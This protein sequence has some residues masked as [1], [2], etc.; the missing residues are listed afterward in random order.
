MKLIYNLL[1]AGLI[2][3][4]AGC[5]DNLDVSPIDNIDAE[6]ALETSAD[7]E[8]LV[9]GAYDAMGDGDL[10]GG[11]MQRDAELLADDGD[12]FWDGTFVAPGEIWTK[13][14]QITND[15]A[16]TTWLDAYRAINI[17]NL[18]LDNLDLVVEAKR[19]TV[20]GDAKFVRGLM[21]FEL[22]RLY[23]KTYTD[24]NPSTNPGVP[25]ILTPAS[26]DN[27]DENKKVTRASVDAIYQQVISDLID[28]ENLL[29]KSNGFFANTYVA[30][31]ILSRVYLMQHNYNQAAIS[32]NKVIKSG[33][34]SLLNNY[35]DN[36]N[37]TSA[38]PGLPTSS[39]DVFSIQVTDQDGVNNLNTFFADADYSG[40]GDIYVE[41]QHFDRYEPGDERLDLFYYDYRTGKWNNQYGNINIVRLS[42][43]Y[44][45]RAEANFATGLSLGD[46]PLNDINLIRNRVGLNPL[47]SV[48]LDAILNER[49]L[50]LAFEGHL[51]HDLKRRGFSVGDL[52]FNDGNLIF[53][54]PNR[55][56]IINPDLEQNEAYVSN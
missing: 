47:K 44:L 3:G 26:K 31:A 43:M 38:G 51:I 1:T 12:I 2:I 32:A 23:A 33:K 36:F 39:E 54:I 7:V 37:K 8:A 5:A 24:G 35:A 27:L 42:E 56:R 50:E 21:Y 41:P 52:P 29:P 16:E 49:L 13:N 17:S 18:V 19:E 25:L 20:E 4:A 9:I 46:T 28:A 55:E 48:N 15:Q 30:S 22:V 10:L 45:T 6:N 40:R 34:Y 11:N 14:M 53:P